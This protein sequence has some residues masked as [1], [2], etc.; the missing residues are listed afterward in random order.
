MEYFTEEVRKILENIDGII[1]S[2][3]R[4]IP[5]NNK[6]T[7][8][9]ENLGILLEKSF[10]NISKEP[11][12]LNY[13]DCIQSIKDKDYIKL[14]NYGTDFYLSITEIDKRKF[15]SLESVLENNYIGFGFKVIPKEKTVPFALTNIA[16]SIGSVTNKDIPE[17]EVFGSRDL[18]SYNEQP[19][20][21]RKP[22]SDCFDYV[23]SAFKK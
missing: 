5:I 20:G 18:I 21:Y 10:E 14:N 3:G 6:K 1:L 2:D 12:K 13:I 8:L 4:I 22:K 11:S 15:K 7:I 19:N 23:T 17:E 16:P 9:K